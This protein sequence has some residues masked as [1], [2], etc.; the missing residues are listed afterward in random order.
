[1]A[2]PSPY[3]PPCSS[4]S[5]EL[6]IEEQKRAT[7][8]GSLVISCKSDGQDPLVYLRDVLTR[9]P[10]MTNYDDIDPL[11]PGNWTPTAVATGRTA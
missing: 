4:P 1:M 2:T 9:L 7:R 10:R 3:P 8:G 6:T 5:P 11:L